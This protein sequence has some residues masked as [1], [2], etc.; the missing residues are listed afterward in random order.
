MAEDS[1]SA[2][3]CTAASLSPVIRFQSISPTLFKEKSPQKPSCQALS[4]L[5]V[6]F[7]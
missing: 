7:V 1:L 2:C 6:S 4:D 3:P 5:F